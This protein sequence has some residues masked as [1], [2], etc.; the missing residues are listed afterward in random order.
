MYRFSCG[1]MFSVFLGI[2][3]GVLIA[4][5]GHMVSLCLIF[6]GTAK[7]VCKV[8]HHF[9]FSAAVSEDSNFSTFWPTL[10]FVFIITNHLLSSYVLSLIS[11]CMWFLSVQ[12]SPSVVSN[13]LWPHGLQQGLPV[14][15]Q[16][17]SLLKLMSVESV[18]PSNHLILHCPILLLPSISPS[19]RVFSNESVLHIKWPKYW[20]FPL[21]S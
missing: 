13:S 3:L 8:L 10:V 19:I 21:I 5:L 1:H 11:L 16:F 4:L 6:W 18:M 2:Y 7:L 20:S 17:W 12:F 15:C 9:T 14:H